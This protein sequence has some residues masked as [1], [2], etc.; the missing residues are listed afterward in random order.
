M[1]KI[2]GALGKEVRKKEEKEEDHVVQMEREKKEGGCKP[3]EDQ[4]NRV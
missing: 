1:G 3:L 2:E 4:H